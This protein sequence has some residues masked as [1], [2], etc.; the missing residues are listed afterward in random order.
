MANL[1]ILDH[2]GCIWRHC[3]VLWCLLPVWQHHLHQQWPGKSVCACVCVCAITEFFN[4]VGIGQFGHFVRCSV[5]FREI[6][7]GLWSPAFMNTHSSPLDS[8]EKVDNKFVFMLCY[9]NKSVK[10]RFLPQAPYRSATL[11]F[12]SYRQR[13]SIF[14]CIVNLYHVNCFWLPLVLFF[15]FKHPDIHFSL[16]PDSFLF[17]SPSFSLLPLS[18]FCSSSP[19]SFSFSSSSSSAY[20]HQHTDGKPVSL[21]VSSLCL[22]RSFSSCRTV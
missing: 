6:K 17:S 4:F 16:C 5:S 8:H 1:H 20:D 2:A 3:D 19:S 21:P 14:L 11:D 13:N 9:I 15:K 22:S 7:R 12:H 18:L 10:V